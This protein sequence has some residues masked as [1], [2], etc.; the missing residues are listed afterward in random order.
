MA[1]SRRGLPSRPPGVPR[2]A[3][4]ATGVA[5]GGP[6]R[7]ARDSRVRPLGTRNNWTD[8]LALLPG[9]VPRA[10]RLLD[11][12]SRSLQLTGDKRKSDDG[13]RQSS[14][15]EGAGWLRRPRRQRRRRGR[16]TCASRR[17]SPAPSSAAAQARSDPLAA[18]TA[19]IIV[20]CGIPRTVARPS[21][22]PT[23]IGVENRARPR[24][25]RVVRRHDGDLG[26]RNRSGR[27]LLL[28]AAA[29]LRPPD[30]RGE[31]LRGSAPARAAGARA[32]RQRAAGPRG[33]QARARPRRARQGARGPRFLDLL[34]RRHHHGPAGP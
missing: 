10:C 14:G 20:A 11:H 22:G 27:R 19:A 16:P 12:T 5:R 2:G 1:R 3:G 28:V 4:P 29:Q 17:S 30:A 18:A 34:R 25:A 8:S 23:M 31:A 32:Q 21:H 15:G 26:R 7:A 33:G 24:D 13:G 9:R 6:Q